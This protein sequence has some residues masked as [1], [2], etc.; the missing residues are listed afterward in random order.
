MLHLFEVLT[1][2]LSFE[3]L[4][5]SLQ[6]ESGINSVSSEL[7][8]L[9]S[10]LYFFEFMNYL[11]LNPNF[12]ALENASNF[13]E[14]SSSFELLLVELTKFFF[15]PM[16]VGLTK[17]FFELMLVELISSSALPKSFVFE[18]P[19]FVLLTIFSLNYRFCLIR[20]QNIQI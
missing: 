18:F 10:S 4:F 14:N 1:L 6:V 3:Q 17:F 12:L 11:G 16:L 20:P 19:H 13:W 15:E 5:D 8:G 7:S 9:V 2:Q